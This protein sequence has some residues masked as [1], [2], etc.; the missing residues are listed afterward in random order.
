MEYIFAPMEGIT[1]RVFRELHAQFFPG[2]DRYGIPFVSP[3]QVHHLP[4]RE[5]RELEPGALG[6]ARLIPQILSKNAADFV[7]CASE[8]AAMGYPEAELNLGCPS[9]TVV[10]KGKGAG[11]LRDLPA[12]RVLL[13]EICDKSPLPVSVKTRLGLECPEEAG[14]L[15]ELLA[16]FPLHRLTVHPRTRRELYGGQPHVEVFRALAA[17]L[18][19]PLYYNGNL[20]TEASCAAVGA[21]LPGLAGLMLGRGL[22]ADPALVSRCKGL[23]PG[24][25]AL[26]EFHGALCRAYLAVMH[27][28]Q[29]VTPK[30]KELWYYLC[31]GLEDGEAAW[32]SVRRCKTWAELAPLTEALLRQP[33]R[34]PDFSRIAQESLVVV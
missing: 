30:L 18:P 1:S 12:L 21:A 32:R 16:Q 14:P 5:R 10:G 23:D 7:W 29:A 19:G 15:W 25:E 3:T 28:N 20:F 31:L 24:P 9:G 34:A 4:E 11:L 17:A 33:R 22:L 13:S 26:R 27:P 8:L 2:V 6:P